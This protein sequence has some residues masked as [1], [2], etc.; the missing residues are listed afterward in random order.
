MQ[1]DQEFRD[2]DSE[3]QTPEVGDAGSEIRN[4]NL[5]IRI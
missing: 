3:I 2:S 5:E 1:A 4:P